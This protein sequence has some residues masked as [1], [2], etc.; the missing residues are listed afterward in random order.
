MRHLDSTPGWGLLSR[1]ALSSFALVCYCCCS[2]N[3]AEECTDP[4]R[5]IFQPST[6]SHDR[7]SGARVAQYS[8]PAP[9]EPLPDQRLVTSGY[10]R[11]RTSFRGP[12][13]SVD[14]YYQVQNYANGRGGLDAEW[15]RFHDAWRQSITAGGFYN[16]RGIDYGYGHPGYGYP[17]YG[18]PGYGHP[19]YGHPGYGHPG[20]GHPGHGYP[21]YGHPGYGRPRPGRPGGG[22]PAGRRGGVP[23]VD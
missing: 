23:A 6:F 8:R 1:S 2:L 18:H 3:G 9:V 10:R 16:S 21:G 17:G 13:G 5:W 19:G 22:G 20:Y 15:E 11:T 7:L 14:T 4:P 12:D